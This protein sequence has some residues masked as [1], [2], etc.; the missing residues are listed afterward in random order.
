MIRKDPALCILITAFTVIYAVRMFRNHPWYDEL[1]T[2]YSFISKGPVYAAIHWPLPNNHLGYSALS[3]FLNY[4]GNPTIALR[5]VSFLCAVANLILIAKIS[6][7]LISGAGSICAALCAANFLVHGLSVQGRGYTLATTCYLTALLSLLTIIKKQEDDRGLIEGATKK[8]RSG[9]RKHT[10]YI[11]FAIS[12]PLGLYTVMSS[13][14]WVVSVCVFGG[15]FLLCNLEFKKLRKLILSAATGA[16]F[17]L[18]LYGT[19][20]LAIGSNLLSKEEGSGF[21]GIYQ[22]SI[23][24]AA[25]FAALRR[26]AEYMLATPYIQSIDRKE[27]FTGMPA[28]LKGLF[29]QFYPHGGIVVILILLAALILGG[30]AFFKDRR[31]IAGCY[32]LCTIPL[33]PIL[34]LIQSVHP[35]LRVSSWFG[36]PAALAAVYVVLRIAGFSRKKR[37]G[38]AGSDIGNLKEK[39][40]G[41][42]TDGTPHWYRFRKWLMPLVVLASVLVVLTPAYRAPLAGREN[43]VEEA[44]QLY[45]AKYD[46]IDSIFYT[47]D[48][49][50]YVIKF[51]HGEE[52]EE[53]VPGEAKLM[54]L[55]EE[56]SMPDPGAGNDLQ[57]DDG[58][59]APGWP[60]LYGRA[61]L[62]YE[63]IGDR[64]ELLGTAGSYEVFLKR[65]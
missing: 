38:K 63:T 49:Q 28:Y 24:K 4:L 30:F 60:V 5:G 26:G 15:I 40:K 11:L 21:T 39:T 62:D 52:P 36:A 35:Y 50:K 56:L 25:P 34:F 55:P 1:Y 47:D 37:S 19:V 65:E 17:T 43:G 45:Y 22:L 7:R 9:F 16:I 3:G 27:A 23:I 57:A 2:Y 51:Y 12:L 46:R 41:S 48:Y 8:N 6:D 53:K 29:D 33:L 31:D 32:F 18:I 59:A 20:W 13:T 42:E 58:E 54:L 10:P 44:L 14:Y 64:Y 61:D